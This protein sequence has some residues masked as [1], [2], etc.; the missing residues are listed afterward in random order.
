MHG[1]FVMYG[2]DMSRPRRSRRSEEG[3]ELRQ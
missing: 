3:H 1:A 2:R